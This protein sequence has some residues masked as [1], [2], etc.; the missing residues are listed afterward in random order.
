MEWHHGD[1][2]LKDTFKIYFERLVDD[3]INFC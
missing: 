2:K 3:T 1:E